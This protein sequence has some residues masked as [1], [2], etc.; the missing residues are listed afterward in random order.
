MNQPEASHEVVQPDPGLRRSY[1]LCDKL[2][3]EKKTDATKLVI[4]K[5]SKRLSTEAPQ[6]KY[7]TETKYGCAYMFVSSGDSGELKLQ[8]LERRN[9]SAKDCP[10]NSF[11]NNTNLKNSIYVKHKNTSFTNNKKSSLDKKK[12]HKYLYHSLL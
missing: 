2:L 10:A 8:K 5:R 12:E 7:K 3:N 9:L 6:Y 4:R 1:R 11:I